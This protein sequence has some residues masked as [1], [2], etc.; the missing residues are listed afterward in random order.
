MTLSVETETWKLVTQ[1]FP[2][3][4]KQINHNTWKHMLLAKWK[5][6]LSGND[7]L[8]PEL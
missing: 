8:S 2:P 4:W 7:T 3:V 1:W 5:P 6:L